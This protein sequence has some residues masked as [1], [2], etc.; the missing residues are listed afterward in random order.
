MLNTSVRSGK[1]LG[2]LQG[3]H[4]QHIN[5]LQAK[6]EQLEGGIRELNDRLSQEVTLRQDELLEQAA[7]L[8]DAEGA[9]QVS[10]P[11]NQRG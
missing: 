7:S 6:V 9:V 1:K 4:Q 2:S 8:R 10:W 3:T 5:Y 11:P